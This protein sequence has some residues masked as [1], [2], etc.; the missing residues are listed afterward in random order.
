MLHDFHFGG[1]AKYDDQLIGFMNDWF[2]LTNIPTDFVYTAKAFFAF[3]EM[4]KQDF[5][6]HGS[7]VLLIHTGGLQGNQS[8]PEGTLI[9]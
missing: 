5:F 4:V 7:K 9:F 1:Y 2:S 6:P 3:N 8:L